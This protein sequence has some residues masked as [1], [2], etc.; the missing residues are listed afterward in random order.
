MDSK[1]TKQT[2]ENVFGDLSQFMPDETM[3]KRMMEMPAQMTKMV[4]DHSRKTQE[5]SMDYLR[6]VEKIQRE[7]VQ[8]ATAL[9]GQV[10][11]GE[12]NLWEA[13]TK[14]IDSGFDMF[15]Q[16]MGAGKKAA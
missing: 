14:M 4:M 6:Q 1:K 3:V 11:P 16:M 5:A 7:Y 2:N 10:L 8:E 12:A 9:W 13:Q 15:N